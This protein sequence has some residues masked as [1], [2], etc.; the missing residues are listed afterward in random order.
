MQTLASLS[1][2]PGHDTVTQALAWLESI[3]ERE[4]WPT[5]LAF[6]LSLCLDEALSNI[7][8]HGFPSTRDGSPRPHISLS[9]LQADGSIAIDIA[10]N[11]IPFDPTQRASPELSATL[12]DARIGGHGLRLMRHYLQNIEYRRDTDWNRLRLT[13]TPDTDGE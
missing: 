12:D 5:R 4:R 13:A 7:V 10:D 6:K 11:G 8:M 1:L 9:V 2:A 3:A